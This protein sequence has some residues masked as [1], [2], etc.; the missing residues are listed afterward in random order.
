MRGAGCTIND[1]WDRNLDKSVGA[2][3]SN[4]LFIGTENT[5]SSDKGQATCTGR[6]DAET[7]P[8]VLGCPVGRRTGSFVAA[9]L[10]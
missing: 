6:L 8:G 5:P 7:G 9:E 1:M 4:I 3:C 10:V 2:S